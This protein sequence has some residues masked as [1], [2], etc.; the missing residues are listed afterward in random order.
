MLFSFGIILFI[1]SVK[2]LIQC[3]SFPKIFNK[4]GFISSGLADFFFFYLFYLLCNIS[5][6]NML[7]FHVSCISEFCYHI[8]MFM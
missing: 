5:C 2:I 3:V 8:I 7:I 4:S 6:S 1:E